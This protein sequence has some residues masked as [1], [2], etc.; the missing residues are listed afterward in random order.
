MTAR[1]TAE[2]IDEVDKLAAAR[3][4]RTVALGRELWACWFALVVNQERHTAEGFP[5][6]TTPRGVEIVMDGRIEP[7]GYGFQY[8][9]GDI[10]PVLTSDGRR[11][12]R[13]SA[14]VTLSGYDA[15]PGE[16]VDDQQ[17]GGNDA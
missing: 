16:Y 14:D 15:L 9:K 5:P 4:M 7:T 11:L 12:F 8:R 6:L 17:I 3:G 13:V 2:K 10:V 1:E